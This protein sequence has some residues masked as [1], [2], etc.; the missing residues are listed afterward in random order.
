MTLAP[1]TRLGPYEIN[2]P[3]GAGGMGEVYRARDTRL[4]RTV[5][6]KVLPAHVANHPEARQ[7]FER[8][9]RAVSSL[10]HP[11]ICV[12]HDIG[13]EGDI[14]FMVMEYLEGETLAAR[15]GRGPLPLQQAL[16]FATQVADALG[17]AHRQGV[18][19]RDLK[20]ANIMLT[21]TGAKLLD[22][23]LAKFQS[24]ASPGDATLSLAL[25]Q[26]G[27][28]LG[29][30]QY[31]A[32]EQIE[33]REVDGRTDIFS[34][35]AVIYE[36]ITGQ[37]AF[38]GAT[39]TSLVASILGTAP[40]PLENPSLDR[41]VRR[42][43]AK[44]PDQRWQSAM[45]LG[46]E[47]QWAAAPFPSSPH[48]L[49]P[50]SRLPWLAAAVVLLAGLPF[51]VAYFRR[52]ASATVTR[53]VR[54]TLTAPEK[55]VFTTPPAPSPD[56]SKL[57]L[58]AITEGRR[59]LWLRPLDSVSAQPLAGS[60]DAEF[61]FWSPD[62]R[63]IAFFAQGKLKKIAL[64]GGPAQT[65][66]DA[67]IGRGGAWNRD[68]TI[69]FSPN[70][71]SP[72]YQ[73]SSA[74]G[75]PAPVTKLDPSR[76]ENS[77]RWPSFLPDGRRFL[78]WSRSNQPGKNA[79]FVGSLDATPARLL[80]P[81]NSSSVFVA[82]SGNDKG[83]LLYVNEKTLL[84][85]PLDPDKLA[86]SGDP[87]PLA[88][89]VASV[90]PSNPD[91]FQTSPETLVYG[92]GFASQQQPAWFDRAGK[93]LQAVG[94]AG[95]S[96]R[97][98]LSPDGRRLAL[99]LL[100]FQ[101]GAFDIWVLELARGATSR[102]TFGPGLN[103]FPIWSPD[104]SRL[105]FTSNRQPGSRADL[106]Q[107]LSTGAGEVTPLLA[108]PPGNGA[109]GVDWSADG[110]Y[111]LFEQDR[112]TVDID[113]WVLKTGT[114]GDRQP[115]P[116]LNAGYEERLGQFAPGLPPRWFAYVSNETG[117]KEVYV[118]AFPPSGAKFQVSTQGG[119]EPRWRSDGKELFFRSPD[120]KLMAAPV[121]LGEVFEAGA[122]QVLFE[123]CA[124]PLVPRETTQYGVDAGGQRFL[125]ICSVADAGAAT[126]A[127]VVLN[128]QR[129]LSR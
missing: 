77:H 113:L 57:V 83:Y 40:P 97:P 41:V 53:P 106:F 75:E 38:S 88:Q 89:G 74:G 29:T 66:C 43:L 28:I 18:F 69:V 30:F 117:R 100:D 127:T 44:D 72:L 3:I 99:E 115:K 35:G 55:S 98:Q 105:V 39:H 112:S 16:R 2:A 20:P 110:Q 107:K 7:R 52:P 21:R 125:F 64:A 31:M 48:P 85:H 79:V 10:N 70:V 27:T 81:V 91:G 109:F 73:V 1:G 24:P 104:G 36:M 37:K 87:V 47:I 51:V 4:D 126:A 14:D 103:W 119:S 116:L 6:I 23:G 62:G 76:Q 129:G 71:Q 120:V 68:G 128:W 61:P 94:P 25:T 123:T 32:P 124:R 122:P 82:G 58:A 59:Q 60:D 22:F 65:L 92:G 90:G 121:K 12:L 93:R 114:G 9:A 33:G 84:A 50:S 19:H 5:A 46:A 8:E 78:F 80:L 63:F 96:M 102:L 42:C 95:I 13:R 26:K 34:F 49:L 11:H 17:Q 67:Q 45:D 108:L 54:F 118:Q 101:T 56:G 15:L 111:L 86:L